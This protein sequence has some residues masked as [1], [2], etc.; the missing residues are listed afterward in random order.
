MDEPYRTAEFSL[1]ARQTLPATVGRRVEPGNLAFPQKGSS[2][3]MNQILSWSHCMTGSFPLTRSFCAVLAGVL[4]L[5]A[6]PS[7]A[8]PLASATSSYAIAPHK[9]L[10]DVKL[11]GS[12]S[13]SQIIN[14][15]GKMFFE[16]KPSCEGWITDHRFTLSYDYADSSPLTISSD[17]STYE[18]FDG[19]SLSFSSRRKRDGEIYEELRGKAEF[20]KPDGSGIARYTIPDG[21]T[22]DL[23][24]N[25]IFPTTHTI[26]LIKRAHEGTKFYKTVIFDGSDEEGPV[27]INSFIGKPFKKGEQSILRRDSSFKEAAAGVIDKTLLGPGWNVRMAF[28][29]TADTGSQSDYEL[30]MA[31]HDNGVISDMIIEYGDFT[32]SQKLVAL[33]KVKPDVCKN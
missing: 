20:T 12:K 24:K 13:G 26:A 25:L 22:F 5:G 29:P 33:E 17:F 19:K 27:E 7:V 1:T 32:V 28:F 21:L 31:F 6:G 18:R 30:T 9:A 8:A 14:I 16:W 10:Y 11:I 23:P 15:R 3:N 2:D 4:L